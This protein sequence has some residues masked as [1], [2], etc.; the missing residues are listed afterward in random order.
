MKKLGRGSLLIKKVCLDNGIPP[1]QWIE[2]PFGV[3]LTF[4]S[5]VIHTDIES[6]MVATI[7]GGNPAG[8]TVS[9]QT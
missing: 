8:F 4:F 9:S 5:S 1:L 6:T 2:D 3:T 7:V